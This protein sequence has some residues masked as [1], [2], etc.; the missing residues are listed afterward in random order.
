MLSKNIQNFV[1]LYLAAQKRAEVHQNANQLLFLLEDKIEISKQL[2]SLFTAGEFHYMKDISS[3]LADEEIAFAGGRDY[4][5][6]VDTHRAR[7]NKWLKQYESGNLKLEN[8]ISVKQLT[9]D[10]AI[11][12]DVYKLKRNLIESAKSICHSALKNKL[13]EDE[14]KIIFNSGLIDAKEER[15]VQETKGALQAFLRQNGITK[16]IAMQI[17]ESA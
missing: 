8:A 12:N 17:L 16:D 4:Q 11:N 13:T 6:R 5:R 2:K 3:I 1:N 10:E 9:T 14:I 15:K 7:L